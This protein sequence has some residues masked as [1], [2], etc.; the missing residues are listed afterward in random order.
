MKKVTLSLVACL[1]VGILAVSLS[2]CSS[3]SDEEAV[4]SETTAATA[5]DTEMKMEESDDDMQSMHEQFAIDSNKLVPSV[6]INVEKDMMKGYNLTLAVENFTFVPENVNNGK[7]SQNEG[8]A[9]I[10]VNGEKL[11]R[12]YSTSFYLGEDQVKAGDK[13]SVTLNTN[14][15]KDLVESNTVIL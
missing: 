5:K 15:H 13:V 3:D 9:H 11:T 8:H 14:T 1:L 4:Q 7:D 10:Y 2:A 6:E 12:L